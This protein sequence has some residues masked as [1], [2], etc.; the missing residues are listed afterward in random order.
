MSRIAAIVAVG[1]AIGMLML[2]V[3]V[4]MLTAYPM[5]NR[6]ARPFVQLGGSAQNV[7]PEAT[8]IPIPAPNAGSVAT[9][10]PIPP[11]RI[12]PVTGVPISQP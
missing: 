9:G 8:G 6:L 12:E 2:A 10:V 11:A 4:L 5:G 3:L 7:A 1:M